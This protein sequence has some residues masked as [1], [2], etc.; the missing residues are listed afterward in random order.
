MDGHQTEVDILSAE[1]ITNYFNW[2]GKAILDDA[3]PLAG[4]TLTHFHS[5]SWEGATP[6]WT[7]QFERE[8]ERRRGYN[9]RI[10]YF[11]GTAIYCRIVYLDQNGNNQRDSGEPFAITAEDGSYSIAG[12][13]PGDYRVVLVSQNH[14]KQTA[15][16]DAVRHVTLSVGWRESDVNFGNCTT[17]P[18]TTLITDGS[19][20]RVNVG[21]DLDET[22]AGVAMD[23]AGNF[24]VTFMRT[25]HRLLEYGVFARRY[26]SAGQPQDQ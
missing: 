16:S 5:V 3:G 1:A 24:V 20:L 21:T 14:W 10:K 4:K 15:P 7:L 13:H 12:L 26:N 22:V 8:L 2:M 6:T 19:E 11:S 25:D 23:A 17:I 18:D 9:L